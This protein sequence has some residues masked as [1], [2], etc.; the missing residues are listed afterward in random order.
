MPP[1]I[2]AVRRLIA[3]IRCAA[4]RWKRQRSDGVDS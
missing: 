4:G 2:A 1:E 3:E